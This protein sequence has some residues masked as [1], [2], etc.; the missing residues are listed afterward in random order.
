MISFLHWKKHYSRYVHRW[1]WVLLCVHGGCLSPRLGHSPPDWGSLPQPLWHCAASPQNT[2]L[3]RS[4]LYDALVPPSVCK[5]QNNQDQH[6]VWLCALIT[7]KI[8]VT[9]HSTKFFCIWGEKTTL[10][11]AQLPLNDPLILPVSCHVFQRVV[12]VTEI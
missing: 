12:N 6:V 10:L 1:V 11:L 8:R 5:G 7:K 4:V 9:E 2:A 3:P